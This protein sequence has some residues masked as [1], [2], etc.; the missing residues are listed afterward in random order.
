MAKQTISIMFSDLYG[1]DET[2]PL[3]KD[4][5]HLVMDYIL[6][7]TQTNHVSYYTVGLYIF[8]YPY[9]NIPHGEHKIRDCDNN[10]TGVQ[11]YDQG[12]KIGIWRTW[13][14]KRF[15]LSEHIYEGDRV[16]KMGWY[17]DGSNKYEGV[18]VNQRSVGL[19][20]FWNKEGECV[21]RYY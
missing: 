9:A 5:F 18:I 16:H 1:T 3:P 14:P 11:Y 10:E 4:L 19:W 15:L 8:N 12:K 21:T 7:E 2:Y 17:E 13:T 20:K 6:L